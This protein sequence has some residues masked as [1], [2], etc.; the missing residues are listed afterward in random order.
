MGIWQYVIYLTVLYFSL[1]FVPAPCFFVLF[2]VCGVFLVAIFFFEH[3]ESMNVSIVYVDGRTWRQAAP[4]PTRR[5]SKF[6][7]PN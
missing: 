4:I 2:L 7:G 5:T 6:S 1:C 3:V